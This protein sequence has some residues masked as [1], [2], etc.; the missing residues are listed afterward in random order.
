M[1]CFFLSFR[2][3]AGSFLIVFIFIFCIILLRVFAFR[4]TSERWQNY[5]YSPV[6]EA[7]LYRQKENV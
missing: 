4:G 3:V 6:A 1:F 5:I 7:F 2:N